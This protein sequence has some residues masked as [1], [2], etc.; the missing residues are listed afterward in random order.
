VKRR[1]KIVHFSVSRSY[2]YEGPFCLSHRRRYL[3]T[4]ASIGISAFNEAVVQ[5]AVSQSK[6][7][8][9]S[10]IGP[11]QHARAAS[12]KE[13]QI[14]TDYNAKITHASKGS[15]MLASHK[16]FIKR[17]MKKQ[18]CHS[19]TDV[20]VVNDDLSYIEDAFHIPHTKRILLSDL[21]VF[22]VRDVGKSGLVI[23]ISDGGCETMVVYVITERQCQ[24][25]GHTRWKTHLEMLKKA[26]KVKP[27][28]MRSPIKKHCTFNVYNFYGKGKDHLSC[29]VSDYAIK[30][31]TSVAIKTECKWGLQDLLNDIEYLTSRGLHLLLSS[32]E[33][34]NVQDKYQLPT[35]FDSK[36][37]YANTIAFAVGCEN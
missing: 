28:A 19:N 25:I 21:E 4:Y 14:K 15:T 3:V 8:P 7:E 33:L 2:I 29:A 17:A 12:T 34:K 11:H 31:K 36:Q 16:M 26:E 18:L 32:S 24:E 9:G 27:P 23:G 10:C 35:A 5:M 20:T 37:K 1:C 6:M 30:W 13:V 22:E